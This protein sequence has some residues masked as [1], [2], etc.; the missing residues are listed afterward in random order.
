MIK[1]VLLY[2]YYLKAF[3]YKLA[4]LKLTVINNKVITIVMNYMRM[5]MRIYLLPLTISI[6][7]IALN[8]NFYSNHNLIIN[9][10]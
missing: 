9:V 5:R 8:Y 6:I 2:Y 1:D 10:K 3:C 7:G 4:Y